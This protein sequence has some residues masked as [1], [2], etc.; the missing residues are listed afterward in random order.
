MDDGFIDYDEDGNE[1]YDCWNC[2]GEGFWSDCFEE[3]ACIDPESGCD[4]C[5][6]RCDVC[7]GKGSYTVIPNEQTPTS[8]PHS[9]LSS[10]TPPNGI[11]RDGSE[12]I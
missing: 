6:R 2:V 9:T 10:E 11:V 8:P 7:N 12:T 1:I 5:L 4:L 3:W